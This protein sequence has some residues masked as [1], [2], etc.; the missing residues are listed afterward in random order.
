MSRNLKSLAENL[1]GF[2]NKNLNVNV[3]EVEIK[4]GDTLGCFEGKIFLTY[5][6]YKFTV[7]FY[8]NSKFKSVRVNAIQPLNNSSCSNVLTRGINA[9]F[10]INPMGKHILR[11]FERLKEIDSK[12]K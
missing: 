5:D 3:L 11:D 1:E 4:Y 9:F 6:E 10:I 8:K 2:F 7:C 12:N